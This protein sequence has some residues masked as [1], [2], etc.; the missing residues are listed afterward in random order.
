M[1]W[2]GEDGLRAVPEPTEDPK[3]L[4]CAW[5]EE[6][7]LLEAVAE[8]E[9]ASSNASKTPPGLRRADGMGRPME[10]KRKEMNN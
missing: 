3:T 4:L 1:P 7:R 2:K 5:K 10:R 6:E 9:R 8:E